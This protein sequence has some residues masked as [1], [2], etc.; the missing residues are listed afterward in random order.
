MPV[1]HMTFRSDRY[2]SDAGGDP[3]ALYV[4]VMH[5]GGAAKVGALESARNAAARLRRVEQKQRQRLPDT[6]AYPMRLAAVGEIAGLNLGQYRGT[7]GRWVYDDRDA[8]DR[9]WAEVEHLESAIRLVLARRLGRLSQ[10]PDW[11]TVERPLGSDESW[12][13]EFRSAWEEVDRLGVLE[14]TE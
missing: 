5:D 3:P 7:D 11:I 1:R 12:V 14:R 6:A 9:R 8:F 10:W 4:M 2:E 13:E